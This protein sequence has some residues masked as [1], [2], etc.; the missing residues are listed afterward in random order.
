M[1][2]ILAAVAVIAAALLTVTPAKAD[3]IVFTPGGLAVVGDDCCR[4]TVGFVPS[5]AVRFRT[6]FGFNAIAFTPTNRAIGVVGGFAAPA[7]IDFERTIR[8]GPFGGRFE[9]QRFRVR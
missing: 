2:K 7:R 6:G 8:R 9:V 1:K 3:V 5:A 4:Q